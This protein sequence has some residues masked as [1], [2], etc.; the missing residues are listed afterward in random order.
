MVAP[1]HDVPPQ[2]LRMRTPLM[3][4]MPITMTTGLKR[5]PNK[6][7]DFLRMAHPETRVAR[8]N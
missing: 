5:G 6:F 4:N 2:R 1:D 7:A 3:E 8:D